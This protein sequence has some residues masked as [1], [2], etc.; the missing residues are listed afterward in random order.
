MPERRKRLEETISALKQQRDELALRIHLAGKE[1][2]GEWSRLDDKLNELTRNYE[3]LK[4]AVGTTADDVW[5]SLKLLGEEIRRG[6][7]RIRKSL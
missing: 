7:D 2:Q 6:F 3:P 5:E 1:A 4:R